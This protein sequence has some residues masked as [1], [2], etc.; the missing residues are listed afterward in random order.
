M[1]N[2]YSRLILIHGSYC[3]RVSFLSA[4]L[5]VFGC[6]ISFAHNSNLPNIASNQN[7]LISLAEEQQ[8]G[9]LV[10]GSLNQV[11]NSQSLAIKLWLN[12]I[13]RPL[14]NHSSLDDKQLQIF[15][16]NNKN[17]NAFAAPGGVIGVHSGLILEAQ[18]VDEL[19]AVLAH[20]IAHISQRHYAYR[21]AKE[22][23]QA[24]IYLGA[25]LASIVLASE[26]DG[27]I[28]EAGL[29]ATQTAL[30]HSQMG[31][32]REH[33]RE[34][35]RVG[36]E[37]MHTAGFDVRK[38]LTMLDLLHS[39]YTQQDPNWAWA[40]SHPVSEERVADIAARIEQLPT[41][42]TSTHYQIDYQL[43]RILLATDLTDTTK[44]SLAS[45]SQQLDPLDNE[46]ALYQDFA[47]A[48]AYLKQQ[49]WQEAEAILAALVKLYPTHGFIWD[50]WMHSL[51]QQGKYQDVISYGKEFMQLGFHRNLAHYYLA[52]ASFALQDMSSAMKF[53]DKI[54]QAQP[55]W[56][57]GWEMLA[58][59]S[60]QSA[61]LSTHRYAMAQWHL[62]RGEFE[63]AKEQ[64][65]LGQ[66]LVTTN[67][68]QTEKLNLIIS[69]A[70]QL[71]RLDAG[72]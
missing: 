25:F 3:L 54:M 15:L 31:Y 39:P 37:L 57:G 22:K 66:Q 27:D 35:D 5:L 6:N 51:L 4:L 40:R 50:R 45:I 20:E 34:A 41:N 44:Q 29:H 59:W 47:L 52:T 71:A 26:V 62:L 9:Q 10:A 23:R 70:E 18:Q 8:I 14:I 38:M 58:Q 28:G 72:L 65:F 33:E 11:T 53:L 30:M 42:E 7:Q 63:Q 68:E 1:I 64:A 56:I 13:V 55:L 49:Q 12:D 16:V 67:S 60:G 46:F 24:P 69:K 2:T 32:S 48:M 17:I 19:V 43:L 61:D 21:I 36:L